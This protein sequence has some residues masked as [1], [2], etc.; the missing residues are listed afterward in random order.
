MDLTENGLLP[1]GI[2]DMDLNQ[3]RE[4]FGK[5]RSTDRRPTLFSK[6]QV[7]LEAAKETGFVRF[8]I[9][10]G[11]FVTSKPD[12]G[13]IDLI[14]VTDPDVFEKSDYAPYEYDMLS[15]RRLRRRFDFDVFV[16][17]MGN[18]AYDEYVDLFSQ[19]KEDIQ[20]RKGV[21]RVII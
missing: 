7:F 12:P 21:V 1:E 13:D 14:V 3:V 9:V 18:S 11:S 20:V 10:D 15:S 16:V 8:V 19:V 17:P 2:H 4:L 5:F 6:L